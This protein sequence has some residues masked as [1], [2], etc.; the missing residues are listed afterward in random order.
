M[1]NIISARGERSLRS[2][3][4]TETG[5]VSRELYTNDDIFQQEL[6][7]IYGRCWLFLG[8]ESQLPNPGDFVVTRMG[9][10]EILMVR[11]R[12]SKQIRAFLNSCA[13]RGMKVCRYDQGNAL[14]FT[15]PFHAWTYDTSGALVGAA[16]Q[17]APNSYN[18]ELDKANWGLR[19]VA[20]IKNYYG[21]IWATWD[22]KAPSFEDYAGPFAEGIRYD[23]ES[24][25]GEDA[26]IEV[27]TPFQKW[28]L[29]SNW[30]VPAFS[31]STDLTHAAMTHRSV[32]AANIGPDRGTL[33][34]GDRS[35]RRG[36]MPSDRYAV[37]D[38]NLGH[39]GNWA[40]YKEMGIPEYLDAWFEDGVDEY[41]RETHARK[42]Q[43]YAERYMPPHG[44]EG[45]GH[46]CVFP[47]FIMDSWRWRFWHPHSV[48]VVE[49][50]SLFGVDK[51]APKHVKDAVRHYV[52]RYNGPTGA[53]ESDD[54]E[55]WNY[56]YAASL[57]NQAKK[58]N[59]YFANGLG[60]GVEGVAGDG[61]PGL[62][63][64]GSHTEEAHRA[65]FSRWLAFMEA[66]SWD[67]LY[68]VNQTKNHRIW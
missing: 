46:F 12:K 41:F 23:C 10:E 14:V 15:C 66:G 40:V 55:N 51:N 67:D 34:G 16:Y 61:H 22:P 35:R 32:N 60:N 26:G 31:S 42:S 19:E 48:G 20:Q 39:G 33:S 68:P 4:D 56:V 62:V 52:M 65:R 37:G 9:T 29:P 45:G 54:M 49:R 53:T 36:S 47:N 17:N 59:Y 64:N 8:H 21:M 7:Q 25:D 57:G 1:V 13:H 11:D 30:K 3:I 6:E 27:F 28:R 18:G 63:F 2:L 50:W 43:K 44:Q 38:H 24:S 5:T 58:R